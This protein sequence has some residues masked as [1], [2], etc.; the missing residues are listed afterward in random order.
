MLTAQCKRLNND[1]KQAK[2]Q[3]EE[4]ERE[5]SRLAGSIAE[6]EMKNDSG[7]RHLK[8]LIKSKEESMV[9][10]DVLKLEVKRLRE[11]LNAAEEERHATAR[12]L[13]EKLLKVDRLTNKYDIICGKLGDDGGEGEHTQ[14]YYV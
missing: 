10:H 5:S 2:R 1:L 3:A 9:G 7:Q 8:Q 14:A 4:G 11:Q 12:E 6:L 13:S